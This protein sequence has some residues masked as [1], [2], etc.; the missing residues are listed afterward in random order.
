MLQINNIGKS[1]G[2]QVLFEGVTCSIGKG[3]RVGLVGRN[4]SGK[5]T[6]FRM[7]LG[8]EHPDTGIMDIPQGY[9]VGHLSQHIRFTAPT[10]LEEAKLSLQPNEDGIDETY[11]VK[12]VLAGLGFT[13]SDLQNSPHRL[14]GGYQIRLNLAKV[15]VS[16]PDLLLLDE[17]TNYLDI[18]S[19]RWLG[20]ELRA[21][22][23]ELI[24]ITHDRDFMDSITTHTMII[25]R[26]RLRKIEGPTHKLYEQ[27]A[28]EEEVYEKTRINDEKKRKEAEQF[29]NR[30]RAQATKARAVQSRIKALQR[31]ERLEK[32][33]RQKTL[34]FSFNEAPFQAKQLLVAE[35]I[36]FGFDRDRLL[37]EGLNLL[38]GKNDRVAIVGKNG[39]GKTTLLNLL[40][41]ELKPSRGVI[42]RHPA[43]KLAY[44]GQTNILRLNEKNTVEEE[45]MD[46]HP[47]H[48]RGA[49]RGIC[50]LMLFSGDDALK[51]I[52]V[53]SGGE[54]SRV[55]L[56]KILVSPSN[57]LFLD[58]P[59]NHLDMESIAS[60][61]EAMEEFEGAIVIVTHNEMILHAIAERL[62]VFDDNKVTVFEGSY[63]DFLDR[64]GW[65]DE[66][67]I[68]SVAGKPA[69]ARE[70]LKR[71]DLRKARADVITR[72]SKALGPMQA[73][74]TELEQT[75]MKLEKKVEDDTKALQDA[76]FHGRALDIQNLSKDINH[77]QKR[78]EPLFEELVSL[79]R[80][81]EKK[82]R[83]FEEELKEI[84]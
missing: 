48:S 22:K 19:I 17:P 25:H 24:L 20:R 26:L 36:S 5:T 72:K 57:M 21:W 37:V 31:H 82:N 62:V 81:F 45:I 1:F 18:V 78:I 44:F 46:V 68:D 30:F 39:K 38:I 10:V 2:E 75:I 15:L 32:L 63:Q 33:T 66:S 8:E 16:E 4:G 28:V 77:A 67:P 52:S 54:K 29:I 61:I 83:E 12:K 84:G 56:G 27:I 74:M 50:G 58:E 11:K 35:D 6:L 49:A 47:D 40:A 43:A 14:S 13:E 64:V 76:T 42:T 3:E 69:E 59:T 9:R 71:K 80:E 60:L 7:I 53:L 23:G 41:A 70:G 73:R 51:R 34:D 65:K 55:L 79:T